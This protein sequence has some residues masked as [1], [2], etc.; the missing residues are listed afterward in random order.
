MAE[1]IQHIFSYNDFERSAYF[2][3]CFNKLASLLNFRTP[4]D[5]GK[6]DM[7]AAVD[8]VGLHCGEMEVVF[9][10]WNTDDA[11]NSDYSKDFPYEYLVKSKN[12]EL[13]GWLSLQYEQLHVVFLYNHSGV[14]LEQW[15]VSTNHSLRQKSGLNRT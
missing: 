3:V 7:E 5:E 13:M 1:S 9:K 8:A 4:L 2:V 11:T 6:E 15:V 12:K 10:S 14:D